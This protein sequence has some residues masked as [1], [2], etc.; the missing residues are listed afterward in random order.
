MRR[1]HTVDNSGQGDCDWS[2]PYGIVKRM[3]IRI[4]GLDKIQRMLRDAQ[5][6]A[7]SLNGELGQLS[8]KPDDLSS[9]EAAIAEARAL[10]DERLGPW[11]GN[12]LVDKMA[13]GAKAQFE[14][15]VHR[16][17][18]EHRLSK[19]PSATQHGDAVADAL[20]AVR[21][22]IGDLRRADYQTFDRHSEK[23]AR[24]LDSE[25]LRPVVDR[26]TSGLDL[27]AWL[28]DGLATEGGMVGSAKLDWPQNDEA[29]LGLAIL[30]ARRFAGDSR[31]ALNFAHT[32]Y[33]NGTKITPNLQ[34]MVGQ[35][36]VPFERDFSSYVTR[37]TGTAIA[38]DAVA[39][40]PKYPRR[41]FVVHGHDAEARETVARFLE[42]L[43]FETIILHEQANRGRTIIE[44]FEVHADVGFAVVL[45]TP[46]DLG[47][48][49]ET[50]AQARARQNVILELG[51]FLGKLGRERV[52]AF[53]RG[54]IE[55]PSDILGVVYTEFD[56]HGAWKQAL[57]RELL[58]AD[59]EVEQP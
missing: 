24:Y 6:A 9:V 47:S 58:A 28:K 3:P 35:L 54:A 48:A 7:E 52:V 10:V 12:P 59:Y 43:K 25:A 44:K 22:A 31:A 13:E 49:K 30:L 26:L 1:A 14:E 27:D 16:K 36:F 33:Y 51:Y 17:V 20:Q 29:Q 34:H 2:A 19:L 21:H 8:F 15:L 37:Q 55:L 57:I 38:G 4:T 46:D 39:E 23:L 32:F 53:K 41:V 50:P 45:L 56:E 40:T 11:R 5:R 42:R 18:E